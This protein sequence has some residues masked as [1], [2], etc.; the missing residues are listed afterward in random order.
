M[1]SFQRIKDTFWFLPAVMV[2]GAVFL[3]QLMLGL[4][5]WAEAN[6]ANW[7]PGAVVLGVEGSRGLL[8]AIGGS[9]LAVAG[10]TFSITI[11]VIATASSSYG[12]R[13]VRNFMTDRRNQAVLGT[14]VSTFVYCLLVLRSVTSENEQTGRPSFVPYFAVY[15]ALVLA[16]VNVAAL[17]Y[18]L[19]HIAQSIQVSHLI[20]RVR[21]EL[22]DVVGRLYGPGIDDR[23]TR[24]VDGPEADTIV[25][26]EEAGFVV[27]VNPSPM[28]QIARDQHGRIEL[29][30][31]PGTH[32]VV[33]EPLARVRGEDSEAI[34]SAVRSNVK[35][36]DAR[37]PYQDVRFAVQQLVE[38]AV[39][40]LSP[41]TND[42]YT[43]RNAIDELGGAMV[44]VARNPNPPTGWTDSDGMVR[45]VLPVPTAQDLVDA[46]FDDLRAY[47]SADVNVVRR[48]MR[49]ATRMRR[50]APPELVE[51]ID[52]HIDLML[53]TS[54]EHITD[55]DHERLVADRERIQS[56]H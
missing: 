55:F 52:T 4:D 16:L 46:I 6:S 45:L 49:L 41:G 34:A 29:I 1:L 8:A 33:G 2:I 12:P 51:R 43:A 47:G 31:T 21:L 14:F 53:A 11:S 35:L 38:M 48:S 32:V 5:R 15:L 17:V 25:L 24:T 40:A 39:R 26:A 56:T 20:R 42:P 30:A 27:F 50:V 9:V 3:A 36:G 13:L 10:T 37:A 54:A 19:H 28:L 23:Q 22:E 44:T 18:F 7:I